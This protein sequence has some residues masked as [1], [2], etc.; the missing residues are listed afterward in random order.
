MSIRT[1]TPESEAQAPRDGPDYRTVKA[2]FQ[3]CRTLAAAVDAQREKIQRIRDVAGKCTQNLSGLPGGGGDKVG[4][5]VEQ[6][7]TEE[8]ELRR[9][10]TRLCNLRIEATRRAYCLTSAKQADFICR[11]YVERKSLNAIANEELI[12]NNTTVS[13]AIRSGC[14]YLAEM[15]DRPEDWT[16]DK[17]SQKNADFFGAQFESDPNDSITN[18]C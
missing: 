13:E 14:T 6:L 8:R 18:S 9:M 11:F 10:E 1:W 2:W 4:F 17:S 3:Q 16:I 5:A 15:F 12:R 7:D